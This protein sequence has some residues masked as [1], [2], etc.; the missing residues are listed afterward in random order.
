MDLSIHFHDIEPDSAG[1]LPWMAVGYRPSDICAMTPPEGGVTPIVLVTQASEDVA[2]KAHETQLVPEAK[3]MSQDA[4]DSMITSM[5]PLEDSDEYMNVSIEAP[6]ASTAVQIARST[7]SIASDDTVSLHFKQSVDEKPEVMNLMYAIGMTS[8]L[9]FHTTR[10]CF[11]VQPT[12]CVGA[13]SE[14]EGITIDLG[15]D[16]KK[17][18]EASVKSSAN[19]ASAGIMIALS[20]MAAVMI[21]M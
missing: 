12:Q 11:E 10:G 14:K 2:P 15:V 18:D 13:S 4:F 16:Q 20:V 17:V 9:G 7:S 6:M 5:R 21:G 1:L 19:V 3:A 8:E